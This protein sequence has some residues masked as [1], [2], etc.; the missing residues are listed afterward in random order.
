MQTPLLTRRR[1]RDDVRDLLK[2]M[3]RDGAL[4]GGARLDEVRLSERLGVSRTPL[5]EAL[6]AIEAEGMVRSTPN[7][8]FI[9]VR[10]DAELVR[11]IYPI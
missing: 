8:G 7:R 4:P 9:V 3:I 5:R 6:I 2:S 11:E 1:A 10:A